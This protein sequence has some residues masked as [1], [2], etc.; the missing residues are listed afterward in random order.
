MNSDSQNRFVHCATS[1]AEQTLQIIA[2]LPVP[3]GLEGRI[4]KAIR[5]APR[6]GL[7]LGWPSPFDLRRQWMR[8]VAAASIAFVVAGGSWGVCW[9]VQQG[10][11]AK[12]IVLPAH[13]SAPG[14]FSGAAAIRTPQT[15]SGPVLTHSA[16]ATSRSAKTF[17]KASSPAHQSPATVGGSAALDAPLR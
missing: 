12:L 16:K 3:K 2:R 6:R 17:R 8:T 15:L 10:Q 5:S 4:V 7:L 9:R 11:P 13:V 14:T 1:E